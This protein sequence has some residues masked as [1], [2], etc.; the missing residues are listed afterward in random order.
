MKKVQIPVKW[1]PKCHRT[2]YPNLYEKGLQIS[3]HNK[4]LISVDFLLDL[5]NVLKTGGALIETIQQRIRLLGATNDLEEIET[6]L[7]SISIKLEKST[8]ALASILI[9]VSDLDDV[10]CYVCGAAPKIVSSGECIMCKMSIP[11]LPT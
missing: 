3:L 5:V 10:L 6:D 9:R 4:L 11:L 2:F 7:S 8:I 1:C